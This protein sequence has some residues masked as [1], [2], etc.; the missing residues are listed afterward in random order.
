MYK[1]FCIDSSE[2]PTIQEKISNMVGYFP[3]PPVD[4]RYLRT[5]DMGVKVEKH[6]QHLMYGRNNVVDEDSF[7]G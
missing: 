6:H 3:V 5:Q 4:L 2:V 1:F 7:V